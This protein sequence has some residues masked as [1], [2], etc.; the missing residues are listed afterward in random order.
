MEKEFSPLI[1][2]PNRFVCR[3]SKVLKTINNPPG[4]DNSDYISIIKGEI[5]D[6]FRVNSKKEYMITTQDSGYIGEIEGE[7]SDYFVTKR[8]YRDIKIDEILC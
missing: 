7:I 3:Q 5:Y 4:R 8:E 6:V 1:E 2:K